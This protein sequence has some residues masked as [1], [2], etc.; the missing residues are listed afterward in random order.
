MGLLKS[1][2]KWL[3]LANMD[4]DTRR[5]AVPRSWRRNFEK[6]LV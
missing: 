3:G 2:V 1:H 5:T 4:G 6:K